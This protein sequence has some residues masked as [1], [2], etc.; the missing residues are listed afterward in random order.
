MTEVLVELPEYTLTRNEALYCEAIGHLRH[1]AN[2]GR[3]NGHALARDGRD[4][5]VLGAYGEYVVSL[6]LDR[7]WRPVVD[8]PWTEIDGDVGPLQV[9]STFNGRDPHLITHQRDRDDAVFILVSRQVWNTFRI[10]GWL[11]GAQAKDRRNWGDK[12]RNGR[13]AFFTPAVE[14]NS[15]DSLVARIGRPTPREVLA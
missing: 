2:L 3:A 5:D 13:P 7:S 8:D 1:T 11:T 12:Y 9:R 6:W 10:E 15:P 4:E 14:L